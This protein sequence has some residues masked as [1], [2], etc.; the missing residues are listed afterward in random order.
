MMFS[1]RAAVKG[2]ENVPWNKHQDI[3]KTKFKAWM[4]ATYCMSKLRHRQES[5]C[6]REWRRNYS[7]DLVL[8]P[9]LESYP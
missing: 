9:H 4:V 7:R 6:F 8:R 5:L 3:Q 2:L 1:Y